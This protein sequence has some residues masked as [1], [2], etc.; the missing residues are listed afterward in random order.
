MTDRLPQTT[1]R[2]LIQALE[3]LGFS[4]VGQKG[5]HISLRR[6]SYTTTV[7]YHNQELRRGLLFAILKQAGLSIEDIRPY[8]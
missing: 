4:I 8:L 3:K 5:S 1:P 2:K 6:G 7:A